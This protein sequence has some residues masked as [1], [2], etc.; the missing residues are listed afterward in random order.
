MVT[1]KNKLNQML[2]VNI[3]DESAIIF[4]AKQQKELTSVQ[5][6]APEM[7]AHVA[8][9]NIVVLRITE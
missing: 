9:G 5:F 2:V 3:P 8:R 6:Q 7:Q 1:V 4:L